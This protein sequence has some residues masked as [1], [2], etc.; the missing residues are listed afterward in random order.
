MPVTDLDFAGKF[1]LLYFGYTFCPDVCPEELDRMALIVDA[2]GWLFP[3][4]IVSYLK[5]RERI[6]Q[7]TPWPR[8]RRS[9]LYQ[10]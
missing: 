4:L 10:L 7:G 9:S 3:F 2:L 8:C 1:M 6:R 5:N